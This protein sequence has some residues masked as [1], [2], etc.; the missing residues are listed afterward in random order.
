M[1]ETENSQDEVIRK[2]YEFK[3]QVGILDIYI[4]KTY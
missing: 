2:E 3:K 4:L 1:S